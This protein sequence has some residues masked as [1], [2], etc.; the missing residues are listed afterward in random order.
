MG[1]RADVAPI[2]TNNSRIGKQKEW[3]L[4]FPS[5]FFFPF[6]VSFSIY[7][8]FLKLHPFSIRRDE[9]GSLGGK[10]TKAHKFFIKSFYTSLAQGK[11]EFFPSSII[12]NKVGFFS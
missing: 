11:I 1:K 4:F 5:F 7:L 3:R 12:W 8:F 6:F 9:E 2:S 10:E